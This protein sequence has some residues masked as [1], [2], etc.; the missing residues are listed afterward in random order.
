V[1][2]ATRDTAAAEQRLNAVLLAHP[3]RLDAYELLGGLYVRQGN[4]A[5]AIEKY[6]ALA[7]R[8]PS[9]TVPATIVGMLL[10]RSDR[11][12][13]RTQYEAVLAKNPRAG[14]AA[15]NLA[16]MLAEDGRF[17]D[18]MR[19]ARVAVEE[20]RNRPEPHD[21]LGWI[22]LKNNQSVEAIAEFSK[23]VDLAPRNTLYRDHL[24]QAKTALTASR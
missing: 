17:D 8:S 13:A 22:Y 9:A 2:L 19:W 1:D 12:A 7:S 14:V 21:T 23:A 10:E 11:L 4:D 5:A 24:Q 16:W 15:N 3:D 20:M 18:A 6:R